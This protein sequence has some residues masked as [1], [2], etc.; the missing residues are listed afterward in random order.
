MLTRDE[1]ARFAIMSSTDDTADAIS[2]AQI[3]A[4]RALLDWTVVDAASRMGLGKNT[5]N[6]I[7]TGRSVASERTLRD[8]VAV[9][10]DAGIRFVSTGNAQGVL[11]Q[12]EGE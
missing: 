9:F 10:E 5:L 8:I 7:E 4:A 1:A 6:R 3:R 11:I 12:S 2:P